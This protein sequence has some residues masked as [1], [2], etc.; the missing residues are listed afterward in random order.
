MIKNDII[1]CQEVWGIKAGDVL[2]IDGFNKPEY[3][4]RTNRRG[5]GVA[6]YIRKGIKYVVLDTPFVQNIMESIGI[7]VTLGNENFTIINC[8]R[9][10]SNMIALDT[11]TTWIHRNINNKLILVGDFNINT[12]NNSRF[13]LEYVRIVNNLGLRNVINDVTRLESMTCIDHILVSDD[14]Q[15]SF[16]ISNIQLADHLA[17]TASIQCQD[18]CEQKIIEYR[19]ESS[20]NITK[21]VNAI[22]EVKWEDIMT[23]ELDQDTNNLVETIK[24][25][26]NK[27]VPQIRRK[28]NKRHD[29][30]NEWMDT[31]LLE[32][33]EK[34]RK[35]AIKAKI[36]KGVH[37]TAYKLELKSYKRSI[38][39]TKN[40]YWNNKLN[41]CKGS[42]KEI[43]NILNKKVKIKDSQSEISVLVV[44][45]RQITDDMEIA[46]ALSTHFETAALDLTR[47]IN[48]DPNSHSEYL[49]KIHTP[50]SFT[51]IDTNVTRKIIKSLK[52][53]RSSGFDGISNKL[54]KA[55]AEAICD[56]ITKLI[57]KSLSTGCFPECLKIAKV[58]PIYKKGDKLDM[59]NYRPI[60]LL[61]ALSKVWEKAINNQITK[62]LEDKEIIP[63]T[64]YGFVRGKNTIHAIQHLIGEINNGK[65][66]K[67][68]VA[69]VFIDVS[70]AFDSCSHNIIISKFKSTGL[71]EIGVKLI[72]N[73][74]SNRKQSVQ[75]R[76]HTSGEIII[77]IGVGQGTIMGPTMFK[78]YIHDLT[79]ITLLLAIL[80]ADD[81]T[82]VIVGDT[83]EE[84]NER[85]N[86]ELEKVRKWFLSNGLILHP[87][88][89]R[90]LVFGRDE[91]IHLYLGNQEIK[92]CGTNHQ[93]KSF[94][95]LGIEID[96][97]LSWHHHI[98]NVTNKISKGTY[99]LFRYKKLLNTK[100]KLAIFNAFVKPH[101][102]YGLSVWGGSKGRAMSMLIKTYKKAVRLL[103]IGKIHVE[104]L[105]KKYN[106]L[107]INDE[108]KLSL[109]K[110]A[111]EC[112]K[113][114]SN[115]NI[116]ISERQGRIGL[117]TTR[118]YNN[119]RRRYKNA[120]NN[121]I[122]N[123]EKTLNTNYN[124]ISNAQNV[125]LLIKHIK[126]ST[127]R[128]IIR[129]Y[130]VT[131]WAVSSATKILLKLGKL[132]S[133]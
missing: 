51:P 110:T 75:I 120:D 81:T 71:D 104:P 57:N 96:Q 10:P 15:G 32:K 78:T 59:N 90:L 105:L 99:L 56:P 8:Y 22:K 13:T 100:G 21:F 118:R 44:N 61:P 65:K 40:E 129:E 14:V 108:Y 80:F 30:I 11:L 85:G 127:F 48:Y 102:L 107:S 37:V 116:Y 17:V 109:L 70:K 39:T 2:E 63:P 62:V 29:P 18:D 97:K 19:Q 117:R 34:L 95:M 114:N 69:A 101:I 94:K 113:G 66:N 1:C 84:V 86:S 45:N 83:I 119:T 58:I 72:K 98:I 73:Y 79:D 82:L 77:E 7:K 38:E 46:S 9:P 25:N 64:Q 60:S 112:V 93:E 111:W 68:I 53:K 36:K 131:T 41:D 33:R 6:L 12:L 3:R 43:W 27:Y 23:G 125:K 31:T 4:L 89:S 20:D 35:L 26:Y 47:N 76:L 132:R 130:D 128:S 122:Y 5:G 67:K 50:W 92:K 106:L 54:I 115:L 121:L 88:K 28:L 124:R 16:E 24:Y 74:L 42:T 126:K 87:D 49:T 91:D 55:C 133:K 103:D 52:P 123:L